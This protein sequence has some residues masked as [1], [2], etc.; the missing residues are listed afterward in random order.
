MALQH[1]TTLDLF[2]FCTFLDDVSDFEAGFGALARLLRTH[3][4]STRPHATIIARKGRRSSRFT[5]QEL[6]AS[7]N[8]HHARR[9][10]QS[11]HLIGGGPSSSS[12][13]DAIVKTLRERHML[14]SSVQEP[15]LYQLS[16]PSW[17][18]WVLP[19]FR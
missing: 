18:R 7:W 15:S 13:A 12:A 17:G 6:S 11:K 9:R 8:S 1:P 3:R 4:G 14:L 10:Q 2:F 16:L 19:A 5:H